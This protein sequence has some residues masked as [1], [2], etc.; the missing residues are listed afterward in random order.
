MTFWNLGIR[1]DINSVAV[2]TW[3]V[4]DDSRAGDGNLVGL[5]VLQPWRDRLDLPIQA[6]P[7]ASA[8][9]LDGG[10]LGLMD[11]AASACCSAASMLAAGLVPAA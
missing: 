9:D 1:E 10:D 11:W 6:V 7:A 3:P 8:G 5:T 4:D 2:A